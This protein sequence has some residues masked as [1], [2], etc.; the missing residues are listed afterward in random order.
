[1]RTVTSMSDVHYLL[2]NVNVD[3]AS[4]GLLAGGC[5]ACRNRKGA[6]NAGPV[7]KTLFRNG[8]GPCGGNA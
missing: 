8:R 7:D 6:R 5:R 4:K 2:F 3:K 1:M